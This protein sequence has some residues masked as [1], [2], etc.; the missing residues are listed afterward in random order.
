MVSKTGINMKYVSVVVAALVVLSGCNGQQKSIVTAQNRMVAAEK[1]YV[2]EYDAAINNS[3]SAGCQA[4]T[5]KYLKAVQK[6]D[7]SGCP[8]DYQ[9]AMSD[10]ENSL[11]AISGYFSGTSS[12]ENI[13]QL[14]TLQN[15]RL[16][17]T[18]KLND[19]AQG[20]G[21]IIL[22][23]AT[24][25]LQKAAL[26]DS[27]TTAYNQLADAEANYINENDAAV[28]NN[29]LAG[30][31][32]ATTKYLKAV[33]NIDLSGCPA[34]YQQAMNKLGISLSAI[35]GYLS[36]VKRL[37]T[38]DDNMNS[39]QNA[40]LEATLKLNEVAQEHGMIMLETA[41][42]AG[43]EETLSDLVMKTHNEVFAAEENYATEYDVAAE[44]GDLAGCQAATTT[45]LKALQNIDLSECPADYQQAMSDLEN[46]L[47][48]ISRYLSGVKSFENIDDQ[49]IALQDAR[50]NMT[51]KLNEVAEGHGVIM[52][53][54]ESNLADLIGAAHNQM[55]AAEQN[56][57]REYKAAVDNS[58]FAGCQ[59]ATTSYLK[60]VQ[61]IDLSGCPAD[62][63]QAM[64]KLE[65]SLSEISGYFSGANRFENIDDEFIALQDARLDAT[66]N[67]N[68][69]AQGHGV[70]IIND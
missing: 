9:Q 17:A 29:D 35:S 62:Y 68:N 16:A 50:L 11:S 22:E 32:A 4:A 55:V 20:H 31:Q 39:L 48:D 2:K 44:N 42:D 40:R 37:E 61:N 34:D 18:L 64:N 57:V 26:S 49:W 67:L 47:S 69:V 21:M 63:Q 66:L 19:V 30:C 36:G 10:L 24:D 1:N 5:A 45:Y 51:F 12:F 3:D 25:A 53:E 7:L 23:P 54:R 14:M 38:V 6:I 15:A 70:T 56:Y 8:A 52:S 43:Q 13:D 58:D 60:A 33:Q 41:T 28:R 27:I 46:S 65:N 59:A